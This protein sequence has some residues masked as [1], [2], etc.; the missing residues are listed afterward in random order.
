MGEKPWACAL[1]IQLVEKNKEAW[2]VGFEF[3]PVSFLTCI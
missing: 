1:L 2:G 3:E